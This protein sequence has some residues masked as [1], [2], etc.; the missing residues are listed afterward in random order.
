MSSV[1]CFMSC[2]L[3]IR[4]YLLPLSNCSRLIWWAVTTVLT[5]LGWPGCQS[6]DGSS[7]VVTFTWDTSAELPLS[8]RAACEGQFTV[9]YKHSSCKSC[10][11][12]A[13]NCI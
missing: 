10:G 6:W 4:I 12:N 2:L 7:E 1:K 13:A 8:A 5:F 3:F 11:I 9:T